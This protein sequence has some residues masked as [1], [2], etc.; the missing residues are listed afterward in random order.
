MKNR[1]KEKYAYSG[2]G[3]KLDSASSWS[4]SNEFVRNVMI[5]GVDDSSSSCFDN[6]KKDF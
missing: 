5:F 6:R 1:D 4:F 3:V 2:Y